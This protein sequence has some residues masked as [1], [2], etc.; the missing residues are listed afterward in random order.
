MGATTNTFTNNITQLTATCQAE[1]DKLDALYKV[2]K[3]LNAQA[4]AQIKIMD[5][6]AEKHMP[7]GTQTAGSEERVEKDPAYIK[8][9]AALDGI[10]KSIILTDAKIRAAKE[11][12][13]TA[14]KALKEENDKFEKYVVKKK[15][16][17]TLKSKKSVP[18]AEGT[19]KA[20]KAYISNSV[21][22]VV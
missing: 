18:A 8:A 19:I 6:V 12:L 10:N 2:R 15:A 3:P 5:D 17:W 9:S 4:N 13:K 11:S 20:T 14:L 16:S 7:G 22:L 21:S 1:V